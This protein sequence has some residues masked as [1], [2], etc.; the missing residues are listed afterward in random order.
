MRVTY[1]PTLPGTVENYEHVPPIVPAQR[2]AQTVQYT[3]T[4]QFDF[5]R[6]WIN[7]N[8]A[9]DCNVRLD[10]DGTTIRWWYAYYLPLGSY[11]VNGT[12]VFSTESLL[13]NMV[14]PFPPWPE[15]TAGMHEWFYD[16]DNPPQFD[17]D[18]SEES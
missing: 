11:M 15:T 2:I 16:A 12:T 5:F 9:N 18:P 1:D 6:D 3:H 10:D 7:F 17:A 8:A 4:N 13:R 14:A